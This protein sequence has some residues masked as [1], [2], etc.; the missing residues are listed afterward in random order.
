MEQ[1]PDKT[2][3]EVNSRMMRKHVCPRLCDHFS[4]HASVQGVSRSLNPLDG[5][6]S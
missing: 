4:L 2:L 3:L 1:A 6:L 5:M